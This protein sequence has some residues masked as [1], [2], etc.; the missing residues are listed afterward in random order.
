MSDKARIGIS[1]SWENETLRS[2]APKSLKEQRAVSPLFNDK[3]N[4][5]L[6]TQLITKVFPI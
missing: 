2:T 4:K 3:T 6:L 1:H 5:T